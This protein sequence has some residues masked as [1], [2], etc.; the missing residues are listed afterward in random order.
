MTFP[1]PTKVDSFATTNPA[2]FKPINATKRPIPTAME[3]FNTFGMASI[4]FPRIPV[5]VKTKNKT[6]DIKTAP[7][8]VCHDNPCPNTTEYVKNA[9]KPIPGPVTIGK[10]AHRAISNVLNTMA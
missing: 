1:S 5:T 6:P 3:D 8:A 9:F 2:F 4:I 10:F 7:S